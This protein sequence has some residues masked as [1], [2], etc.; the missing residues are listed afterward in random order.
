MFSGYVN[1]F[2]TGQSIYK[3]FQEQD[4]DKSKPCYVK[5][6]KLL[7]STV[8]EYS[9][10]FHARTH[11][12]LRMKLPKNRRGSRYIIFTLISFRFI[13][14]CTR[15]TTYVWKRHSAR[16]RAVYEGSVQLNFSMK[17]LLFAQFR[18]LEYLY[19]DYFAQRSIKS[20]IYNKL[21]Q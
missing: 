10:E 14:K 5:L 6:R 17:H 2:C 4:Y 1:Q 19:M 11:C 15:F 8:K 21:R 20:I 16:A 12:L 18:S 3:L 7:L 9:Q 13:L